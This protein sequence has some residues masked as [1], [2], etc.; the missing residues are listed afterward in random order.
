M[1]L[2]QL[3]SEQIRF[4]LDLLP[5]LESEAKACQ[6]IV[7]SK[8]DK[9]FAPDCIPATWSHLYEKPFTE[10]IARAIHVFGLA[11]ELE[12]I[13]N[14]PNKVDAAISVI[15]EVS[16]DDSEL[17]PAE[18][19]EIRPYLGIIFGITT[20]L[21]RSMQCLMA[22]GAYLNELIAIAR[23]GGV[24]GDKAIY[25]A[26][27]ID[28]SAIGTP[29]VINR[30]SQALLEND[31]TFLLSVKKSINGGLSKQAQANTDKIRLVLQVLRESGASR[32]S[33]DELVK[34]F[35]NEL[36]LYSATAKAGTGDSA[37]AIRSIENRMRKAKATT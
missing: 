19:E 16:N 28:P 23:T 14:S 30:L 31:Q 22:Y 12:Q 9:L 10:H 20:S 11:D 1:K 3:S 7:A 36:K 4:L 8:R 37:K 6:D 32:L 17:S 25:K 35:V 13:A 33:D 24:R 2:G 18:K 27:R 21:I 26:V 29:T 34:L 5:R 15:T